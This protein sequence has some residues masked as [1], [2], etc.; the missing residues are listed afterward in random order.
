MLWVI[1]IETGCLNCMA[2]SFKV[3][4]DTT[5]YRLLYY[6]NFNLVVCLDLDSYIVINLRT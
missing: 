5:D 1:H 3:V 6:M 2:N 4:S